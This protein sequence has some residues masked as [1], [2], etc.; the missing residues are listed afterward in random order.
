MMGL[1]TDDEEACTCHMENVLKTVVGVFQSV[2]D[3]C[4][5]PDHTIHTCTHTYVYVYVINTIKT[6]QQQLWLQAV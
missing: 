2:M 3:V 4:S 5:L 6:E 1:Y